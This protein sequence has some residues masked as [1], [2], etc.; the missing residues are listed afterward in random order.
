NQL[1]M[2]DTDQQGRV[3]FASTQATSQ[4]NLGHII[5]QGDDYRGSFRGRGMELRT[6][7][8]GAVRGLKGV[9]L[10]SYAVSAGEPLADVTAASA[11][12]K[13]QKQLADTLS[14]AAKTHLT[15]PLAAHEGVSKANASTLTD[16]AAPIDALSKSLGATVSST[17]YSAANP[18]EGAGKDGDAPHTANAL[19]T[20]AGRAGIATIAGQS[21]HLAAGQTLT[22]GSGKHIN[23]AVANQLRLHA[24]QAIGILA[25]A[26]K[27]D[28]IGLNFIASKGAIDVQAQHD[29]LALR[30]KNDLKLVSANASVE[31]A[32]KKTV[33]LAVSGGAFL[34]IEGGNITF[35]CP[36]KITVHAGNHKFLGGTHLSR[37]M[38]AW[39]TP[40]FDEELALRWPYDQSPIANRKFELTRADGAK[41]QGMTDANG[42]T[43]LQKSLLLEGVVLKLLPE[44]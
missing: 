1:V 6:D 43:G 12:L 38:N 22:I 26:H 20:I 16:A 13:Q 40:K 25:G 4:L 7:S 3:Q 42:R 21:L 9:L 23:L 41:M 24:G 44:A 33:H 37:E 5:H 35:G 29:T 34:T 14:Q 11:L 32:A 2:D 17:D 30:S 39:D 28:G 36:G 10:S 18:S 15:V 8:Y 19:L 31:L 27:A